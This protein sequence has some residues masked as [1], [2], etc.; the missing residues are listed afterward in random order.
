MH[1]RFSATVVAA[2]FLSAPSVLA[3]GFSASGPGG[4]C[5]DP[6]AT[7][8]VWNQNYTGSA[9]T[10]SITLSHPVASLSRVRLTGLQHAARGNLHVLLHGPQG[11]SWNLVVR[12]GFDGTNAGDAGNFLTGDFTL[13]ESGGAS[14]A[15]GA[16]DLPGG[17]YDQYFNAGSGRWTSGVLDVP[18]SAI[19]GPSGTWTLEIRDWRHLDAGALAGWTLEGVEGGFATFCYGT[20]ILAKIGRAHV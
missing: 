4:S 13:V 9:L 16:L 18:L 8:G 6:A 1:L 11:T 2:L 20:G 7:P 19:G 17:T 5:P 10:S 15:Q 14:L 3:L 12:P